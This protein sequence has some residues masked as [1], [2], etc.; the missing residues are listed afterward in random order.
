[1]LKSLWMGAIMIF[2]GGRGAD[3]GTLVME[4]RDIPNSMKK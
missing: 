3:A 4:K 2:K 1:M